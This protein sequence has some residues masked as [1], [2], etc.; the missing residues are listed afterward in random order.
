L[1]KPIIKWAGGKAKYVSTLQAL[2][3]EKFDTYF[4]PFLGGGAMFFSMTHEKN[5]ISDLNSDLVNLY[6]CLQENWSAVW[7]FVQRLQPYQNEQNYLSSRALFNSKPLDLSKQAALFLY[8]NKVGYNGLYRVNKAGEFNVPYGDG[9]PKTIATPEDFRAAS[10]RLQQATI[11]NTSYE[12]LTLRSGDF[13]FL[14]PPYSKVNKT[15]FTSYTSS[16]FSQVK[17]IQYCTQL[18]TNG[19]QWMQTNADT[20]EIRELYKDCNLT[21]LLEHRSINSDG[22]GR[23]PIKC[24]I[25]RNY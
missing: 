21:P 8:L 16:E 14:D 13:V 12:K 10:E 11:L 2:L 9:K 23:N 24:L 7:H 1:G 25:I 19:V 5:V 6:K 22:N 17:L 3:P 15:S 4:E 20:P 18:T